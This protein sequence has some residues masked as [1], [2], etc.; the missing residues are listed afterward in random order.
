MPANGG[1]A[2]QVTR[3]GGMEPIESMDGKFLY[4]IRAGNLKRVPV[5]GGERDG[6]RFTSG[7]GSPLGCY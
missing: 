2:V 7:A 5:D 6:R 1:A 3:D 4:Y